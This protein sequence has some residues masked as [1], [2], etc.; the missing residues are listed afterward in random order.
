L[1]FLHFDEC[2]GGCRSHV[3]TLRNRVSRGVER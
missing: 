3:E 2:N 1:G